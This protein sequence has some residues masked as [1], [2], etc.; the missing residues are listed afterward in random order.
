MNAQELRAL[1]T[2]I[3]KEICNDYPLFLTTDQAAKALDTTRHRL[4]DNNDFGL[5]PIKNRGRTYKYLKNDVVKAIMRQAI[6]S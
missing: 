1:E 5:R 4:G 2:L 3:H 6:G